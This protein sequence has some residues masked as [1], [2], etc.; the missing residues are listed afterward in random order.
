MT[1]FN[2][3]TDLVAHLEQE[4][5]DAE[6]LYKLART[7]MILLTMAGVV[8]G[9]AIGTVV[10]R[11]G[12]VVPIQNIRTSLAELAKGNLDVDVYGVNRKD[13]VGEIAQTTLIFKDNMLKVRAMEASEREARAVKEKRQKEVEEAT[14]R[15][16]TAMSDIVKFVSSAATE[17]QA[18]AQ[19]L[20]STA[21]QTTGQ[22]AV[23]SAASEETLA[24]VQTVASAC[25]ELSASI[26]EISQQVSIS[27]QV[28]NTAVSD[29]GRTPLSSDRPAR[30]RMSRTVRH[31][32]ACF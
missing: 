26:G 10:S 16:Q 30:V 29:A 14:R 19:S 7:V 9:F 20:S 2:Q 31:T 15:F 27:S 28:A 25:E 32:R 21:E 12:I 17:L 22:A 5:A 1:G 13:E 8:G 24:N 4:S 11:K 18:S 23:V 3:R 6:S